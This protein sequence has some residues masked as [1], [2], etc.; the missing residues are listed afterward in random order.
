MIY[1]D[2]V[3][4]IFCK[5][6]EIDFRVFCNYLIEFFYTKMYIIVIAY[7]PNRN[8]GYKHLHAGYDDAINYSNPKK[9][10]P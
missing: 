2:G 10:T 4:K 1:Y 8:D 5:A 3:T 6:P 7:S 9:Q